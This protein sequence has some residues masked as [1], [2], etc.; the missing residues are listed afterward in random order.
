M[1]PMNHSNSWLYG[2]T[3]MSKKARIIG[4]V[5][6]GLMLGC[7]IYVLLSF[8][9]AAPGEVD[10]FDRYAKEMPAPESYWLVTT[11]DGE[12][13][14]AHGPITLLALP[15]G[16]PAYVFDRNGKLIDWTMDMGDD[17][18]FQ[19]AWPMKSS[20]KIGPQEVKKWLLSKKG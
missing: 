6:C 10:T 12:A 3:G 17:P 16:P 13:L 20:R 5:F 8:S 1:Q 7:F 2:F 19:R 18:A 14:M 15:S 9:A 11:K 4:L